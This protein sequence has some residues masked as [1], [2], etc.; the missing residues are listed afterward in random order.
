MRIPAFGLEK[1]GIETQHRP[2]HSKCARIAYTWSDVN[3]FAET[4][5][6]T[7]AWFKTKGRSPRQ[8]K[9]KHILKGGAT[10]RRKKKTH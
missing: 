6:A 10:R 7:H 9:R 8:D 1:A 3:V 2:V 4:K 5:D